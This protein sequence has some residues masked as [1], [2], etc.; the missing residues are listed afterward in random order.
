MILA[1]SSLALPLV[2]DRALALGAGTISDQGGNKTSIIFTK[3]EPPAWLLAFWREIDNKTWGEG[4]N[5]FA[6]DAVCNLGVAEWHGREAIRQG[7][8]EFVDKGF[9]AHHDVAEYWDGGLLKV[10]RGFV[11]M[12]PNDPAAKPVRPAMTHFFYMDPKDPTKV[13]HW[14]GSVGPTA[15]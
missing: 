2:V 4:F 15:F 7:L 6:E 8:R 5:C 12:T 13:K 14:Y 3:T 1:A 10:F 9:T 11:T